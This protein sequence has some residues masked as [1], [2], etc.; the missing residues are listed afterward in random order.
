MP[1][2]KAELLMT[3]YSGQDYRL[4]VCGQ[5]ILGDIKFRVSDQ[6]KKEIYNS[7]NAQSSRIWDFQV[8]ST[9][10]FILEVEVPESHTKTKMMESGCVSVL[11]GFKL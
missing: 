7:K 8:A 1:G 10:Q 6:D 3:F 4:M 5:P 9:Q 2:E 11:V